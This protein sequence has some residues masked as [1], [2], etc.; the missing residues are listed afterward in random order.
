MYNDLF[1]KWW[2]TRA[3]NASNH[4]RIIVPLHPIFIFKMQHHCLASI[5]ITL[6][7]DGRSHILRISE[8]ASCRVKVDFYEVWAGVSCWRGKIPLD[9]R[10][11]WICCLFKDARGIFSISSPF[12]AKNFAI[13][14][15][16]VYFT[17]NFSFEYFGASWWR[18]LLTSGNLFNRH[19]LHDSIRHRVIVLSNCSCSPAYFGLCSPSL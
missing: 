15:P 18:K 19:P 9:S 10:S 5:T 6:S 7:S 11:W 12:S 8:T 17:S 14:S 1:I 3:Y 2:T 4:L 13:G 16:C